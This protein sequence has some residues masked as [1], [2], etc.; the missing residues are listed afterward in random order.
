MQNSLNNLWLD[1]NHQDIQ[2][3]SEAIFGQ[4]NLHFTDDL[5][6]TTGFRV[7]NEHRENPNSDYIVTQ[8]SGANLDPTQVLNVTTG[9]G[10]NSS[11]ANA[12]TSSACS[13]GTGYAAAA[14][15]LRR[16]FFDWHQYHYSVA[17]S[18]CGCNSVFWRQGSE[19]AAGSAYS[20]LNATQLSQIAAARVSGY[21]K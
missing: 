5:T 17:N 2:N 9:Q 3:Q 6:L 10:F 12:N 19:W 1:T 13:S 20:Q 14:P 18:G 15:Q 8:G 21:R 7:T 11:Y 4:T 16:R